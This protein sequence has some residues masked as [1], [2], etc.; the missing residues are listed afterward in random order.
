MKVGTW[1]AM[2]LSHDEADPEPEL[3]VSADRCSK[4]CI[5]SMVLIQKDVSLVENGHDGRIGEGVQGVYHWIKPQVLEP[6][7]SAPREWMFL[8]SDQGHI[9]LVDG[10]GHKPRAVPPR[11][12]GRRRTAPSEAEIHFARRNHFGDVLISYFVDRET[13]T[14]M[15]VAK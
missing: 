15:L 2:R 13:N 9:E 7:G 14:R 10:L 11:T 4:K 6:D 1:L 3:N 5:N 8:G 12:G